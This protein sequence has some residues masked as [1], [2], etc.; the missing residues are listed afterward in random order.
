MTD[1]HAPVMYRRSRAAERRLKRGDSVRTIVIALLANLVIAAA[2][3]VAGLVSGS[4]A[5]LAESAHSLADCS[6]EVLLGVSLRRA[7]RPPDDLHPIGHGR[8]R[9]LWALLAAIASF[10]IGGCFS[11]AIAIYTFRTPRATDHIT[12]AWV[13]L[14]FSFVAEGISWVQSVKQARNEARE[15]GRDVTTHLLRSSDPLVRAVVVEDSAALIGLLLAAAGL[16]ISEVTGNKMADSIASLMIGILLAV[17]AFGLARPLADF[18]VG[19]SLPP[20]QIE[21]LR[22]ILAAGPAVQEVLSL[23]TIYIG[24]E[25]AVVVAKIHLSTSMSGEELTRAMDDLDRALRDACPFVADV[26]LDLTK[27]R[28]TP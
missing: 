9:F 5:M 4:T 1:T 20:E 3:L 25:E 10:L 28:S 15:R 19:R 11:V 7:N 13:V 2:K 8:E 22:A 6:N 21:K 23:L 14:A 27:S 17:T 26:Y 12:T 24:P 16:L 18:L